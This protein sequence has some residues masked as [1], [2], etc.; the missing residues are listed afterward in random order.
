M[1]IE[2]RA[3]NFYNT[4]TD[5]W[6]RITE[7]REYI[8]KLEAENERLSKAWEA[9]QARCTKYEIELGLRRPPDT[10]ENKR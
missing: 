3:G 7:I 10:K 4:D 2:L 1:A 8:Q 9:M 5:Q 6:M